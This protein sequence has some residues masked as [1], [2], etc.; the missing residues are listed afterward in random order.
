MAA[1]KAGYLVTGYEPDR[2]K[3]FKLEQGES[4]IEDVHNATLRNALSSGYGVISRDGA[5]PTFDVAVITVP[6]PL[7]NHL[8]DL[9]YIES[10]ARTLSTHLTERRPEDNKQ[11]VIL[12]STT[13]PGTTRDV[14]IPILEGRSGLKAGEDFLVAFSPERIDPGNPVWNFGNTTKIV[15]GLTPE[16]TEYAVNFYEGMGVPVVTTKTPEAAEL[17][18]I[19]ENTFRH[20]NIALVNE[21][22]RFGNALGVDV[23]D[24][25]EAASSKPYGFMKFTPGPG[26][27]GHCLPVDPIYLSH[28]V[29]T[30]LGE[31]F[32]LIELA[33][34]INNQQPAYI[35]R[36]LQ[37]GLNDRQGRALKRARVL[38]LGLAYKPNTSDLR[39]SPAAK[40]IELMRAKGALVDIVEPFLD[41]PEP[42][43]HLTLPV[44][45]VCYDAVVL[46]TP[47]GTF[48]L[49]RVADEAAY[50]LDTR[51][52]MPTRDNIERL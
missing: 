45:F 23:W 46:L 10:A 13:H 30:T 52:V 35:V 4:Y 40:V 20:V 42:E 28:H 29:Q 32:K 34:E 22:S 24:A 25:I 48:D 49:T 21:L 7:K 50:V 38:A 17:A 3:A 16:S 11:L 2:H 26:V 41:D 6:T 44:S 8:P 15:G 37:D 27:G 31:P 5:L 51:G 18:K 9:S 36:R 39:E 43:D 47:H 14:L 12:E 19:L 33:Q 1:V